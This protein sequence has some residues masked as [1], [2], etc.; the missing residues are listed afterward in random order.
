MLAEMEIV[1]TPMSPGRD[2]EFTEMLAEFRAAGETD[3]YKGQHAIAW[4]GYAAF[5]DLISRMKTGGY[6]TPDIVP[7]DSY[8]IE[9]EG[10]ILGELYIRHRLSPRL[11]KICGHIGY[12]VRPTQRNRGIA[13]AALKIALKLLRQDGIER[14]LVTCN[15]ANAASARVIEVCGGMRIENAETEQGIQRRYW[16]PTAH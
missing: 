6:P 4:Q 10:R 16:V 1:L 15:N 2:A 8:F 3:V 9:A 14:A 7:M 12:K 5:Y 13:T 11:E